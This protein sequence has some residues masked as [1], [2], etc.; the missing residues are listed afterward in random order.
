MNSNDYVSDKPFLEIGSAIAAQSKLTC[1]EVNLNHTSITNKTVENIAEGISK[2]KT[3]EEVNLDFS[4]CDKMTDDSL[5][6]LGKALENS[7]E[8][9]SLIFKLGYQYKINDSGC[10]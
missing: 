5:A 7:P 3:L 10:I 4:N 2:L 6:I 9:N 1:L 8:C